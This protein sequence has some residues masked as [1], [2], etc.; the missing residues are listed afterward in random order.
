MSAK[1]I[2]LFGNFSGD[3]LGNAATLASFLYQLRQRNPDANI[4]CIST[5]GKYVTDTLQL[6]AV[7][8]DALR[9]H[10]FWRIPH[11]GVSA[12][13]RLARESQPN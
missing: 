2:A 4:V 7:D 1:R 3:N 8:I 10:H 6:P 12:H 11:L 9:I 5:P 13:A